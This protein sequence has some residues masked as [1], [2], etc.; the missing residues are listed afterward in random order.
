[1]VKTPDLATT[2]VPPPQNLKVSLLL[3]PFSQPMFT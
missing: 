1:M 3:Q 2:F